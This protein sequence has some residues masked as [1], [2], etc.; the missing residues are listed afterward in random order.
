MRVRGQM[1]LL[2]AIERRTHGQ[3][4]AASKTT[5]G[6]MIQLA[7]S[8]REI[9]ISIGAIIAQIVPLLVG[10]IQKAVEWFSKLSEGTKRN[11]V[12]IA[13]GAALLGP[14][15][16]VTGTAIS[17][18]V[19]LAEVIGFAGGALKSMAAI[20]FGLTALRWA[21][22]ADALEVAYAAL[23][24]RVAHLVP[25]IGALRAA[26]PVLGTL[27]LRMRVLAVSIP[28]VSEAFAGLFASVKNIG[29]LWPILVEG[30]AAAAAGLIPLITAFGALTLA[31]LPWIALAAAVAGAAYLIYKYWGPISDFIGGLCSAIGSTIKTWL[32][33]P[34]EWVT[35]F[36]VG[37]WDI[38]KQAFAAAWGAIKPY[39][40]FI[41]NGASH[42]LTSAWGSV[43]GFFKGM[44]NAVVGIFTWAW[45]KI[46]PIIDGVVNG[47]KWIW[48]KIGGW[49]GI[50]IATGPVG[51]AAYGA[52][53]GLNAIAQHGAQIRAQQA[54]MLAAQRAHAIAAARGFPRRAVGGTEPGF[55]YGG[56]L[57]SPASS[58]RSGASGARHAPPPH[59]KVEIGK[60]ELNIKITTD[61][62]SRVT[63]VK[64]TAPKNMNV[65]TGV[66]NT[67]SGGH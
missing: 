41:G 28:T 31:A 37:A 21:K 48:D 23:D 43:V 44:W 46:K 60:G 19:K 4:L 40:D 57:P 9:K 25:G 61:T 39:V 30:A 36:I 62:G 14:L 7:N 5:Q 64:S 59:Q 16:I 8:F 65:R 29:A 22:G 63:G 50:A 52:A 2:A 42:M 55:R 67:G 18:F 11:L 54:K 3:A 58:A 27:A 6:Q 17:G 13:G 12:M 20:D 10:P 56:Q 38:I 35:D 53:Q 51:M 49:K 24:W 34:M 33:G 32:A 1:S 26:G 47:A 15:L 45:N 66:D